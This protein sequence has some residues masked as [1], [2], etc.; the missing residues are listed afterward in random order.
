MV[1][2]TL[3]HDNAKCRPTFKILVTAVN[4]WTSLHQLK[5]P[6]NVNATTNV[7]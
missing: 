5:C 1:H 2:Q 6:Q 4:S 7:S 3:T